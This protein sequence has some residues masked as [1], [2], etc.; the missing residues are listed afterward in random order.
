MRFL[1]NKWFWFLVIL[2]GG[3][4]WWF[5]GRTAKVVYETETARRGDIR[6]I[7]SVSGVLTPDDSTEVSF[8]LTG[9]LKSVFV[10]K[11]EHVEKGDI[12]AKI[13]DSVLQSQKKE[14]NLAVATAV[15]TEW[16]ARR[17]WDTL[18]PEQKEMKKLASESARAS[19]ATL[20]TSIQKTVLRAPVS[21]TITQVYKDA[22]EMTTMATPVFQ[23]VTGD[24]G[25][26]IEADVPESD[27]SKLALN[28]S[29]SVTFDALTKKDI[30]P[31]TVNFIDP[32]SKVVQ[33]VVYYPTKF[34]LGGL[35]ERFKPG[36]SV[37]LDIETAKHSGVILITRRALQEDTA[38][39]F[40]N[41][42]ENNLK[43]RRDVETGLKDD[44]GNVEILKGLNVG[45]VLVVGV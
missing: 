21:G 36:M 27:V 32:R 28:Q 25:V 34:I 15:Q 13:D 19:L 1:K 39:T 30:F 11:G 31:A 16:L 5:F 38:G 24:G 45:E 33:D 37:N 12:L 26:H 35:D 22:G 29:A 3:G 4:V 23:I 44:E 42:L 17:T 6:E 14:A 43:V 9:T 10:I 18:K 40:V 7:V 20:N 2:I 8:E 41:I